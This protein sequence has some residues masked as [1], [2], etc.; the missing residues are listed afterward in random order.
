MTRKK[1]KVYANVTIEQAQEASRQ[2]AYNANRL[3]SIEVK[4]NGE[5]DRIKAKYQ[6]EIA[7]LTAAQE[8]PTAILSAFA[9]EQQPSWGKKKSCELLHTVIGFRTGMPKVTKDK[10]FT[11]EG[12]TEMVKK[13]FPSLVRTKDELNKE[14]VIEI[15]KDLNLFG[16]IKA[17]CYINVEQEETFFVET[18]K[19]AVAETA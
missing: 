3:S 10:R 5:I 19:E 18:K 12:I 7:E 17:K 9:S 13:A 15:S 11:W 6:D 2:F 8:E 4:M 1:K 14:A 16:E